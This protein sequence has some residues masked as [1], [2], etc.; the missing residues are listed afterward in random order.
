[1]NRRR[2]RLAIAVAIVVILV[3]GEVVLLDS[4]VPIDSYRAGSNNTLTV[5]AESEPSLWARVTS[6]EETADSVTV[7]VKSVRAPLPSTGG[8]REFMLTLQAPLGSR[9]VIDGS[10]GVAVRPAP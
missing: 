3:V 6:V 10:S 1:M 7:R 9:T 4:D 2:R 5:L 8:D